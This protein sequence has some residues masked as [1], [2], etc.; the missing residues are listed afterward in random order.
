MYIHVHVRVYTYVQCTML[1]NHVRSLVGYEN[2]TYGPHLAPYKESVKHVHIQM[3]FH[4]VGRS[5][6]PSGGSYAPES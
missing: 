1:R 6:R 2:N 4:A 3:P 5:F